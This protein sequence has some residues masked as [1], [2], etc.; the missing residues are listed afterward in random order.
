M[1]IAW[2]VYLWMYTANLLNHMKEG[3]E[4]NFECVYDTL[5]LQIHEG[6]RVN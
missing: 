4:I 3:G 6:L 1:V 2:D 5:H